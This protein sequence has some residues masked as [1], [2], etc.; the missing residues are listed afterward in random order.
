MRKAFTII[1]LLVTIAI[2]AMLTGIV[3]AGCSGC[4]NET[5][6]TNPQPTKS[7]TGVEQAQATVEVGSDGLTEEQRN[8]TER[9]A[10]ENMPGSIKYL[11]ILS[12][13]SGELL[14]QSTVDGKVTS[15]GKRLSPYTVTAGSNYVESLGN[16]QRPY[17]IPVNIAGQRY[18]TSEVLQ[19]DGTYGS[20]IPYIYWTDAN[21]AY[22]QQYISGGM[23][24]HISDQPMEFGRVT[25]QIEND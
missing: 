6:V 18:H 23:M 14:L 11:Y 22:H 5:P 21:G 19:D 9:I 12:T 7:S 13:M 10:L 17:G 25:L 3:L 8:I 20:S 15:S 1:E 24:L 2:I 4:S 16:G